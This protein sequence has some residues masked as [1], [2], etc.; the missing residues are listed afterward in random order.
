MNGENN[1]LGRVRIPAGRDGE[2]LI[3]RP[4]GLL[5]RLAR[6]EGRP[7]PGLVHDVLPEIDEVLLLD[8]LYVERPVPR[9][10]HR[11][12]HHHL[13]AR[14]G[15]HGAPDVLFLDGDEV[16]VVKLG[17]EG[18]REARGPAAH[19]EQFVVR[20]RSA[21]LFRHDA[22]D[23]LARLL[24]RVPDAPNAAQLPDDVDV[25]DV[26][27]EIALD[28][29][30]VDPALLGAQHQVDGV[31]GT[32]SLAEAVPHAPG[33]VRH[34]GLPVL[35]DEDVVLGTHLHTAP[36]P[37][38]RPEVDRRMQR[39]GL[40]AALRLHLGYD[41]GP[42]LLPGPPLQGV[43]HDEDEDQE[44]GKSPEQSRF[45]HGTENQC[46]RQSDKRRPA[47][48]EAARRSCPRRTRTAVLKV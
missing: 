5:E 10:L 28:A 14:V 9:H 1:T 37:H 39:V 3:H 27:F 11:L 43:R 2:R 29:R 44:H 15:A 36:A 30:D 24:E 12:G 45:R 42:L 4:L 34:G 35:D 38:A 19:D 20:R 48:R 13:F 7:N 32:G 26:G 22:V 40:L 8:G 25:I 17:P 46:V 41:L 47:F 18:R 16:H 21:P 31:G 23:A 6:L 33:G